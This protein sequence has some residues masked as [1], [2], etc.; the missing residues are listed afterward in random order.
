MSSSNTLTVENL[1]CIR[2]E[3]V[4]FE[5]LSFALSAGKALHV[6]GANGSGKTSL[7][8]LLCGINDADHGLIQWNGNSIQN[9][10]DY[11]KNSAYIGHKDGLKNELSAIENLRF[12]QQLEGSRDEQQLDD[13]LERMQILH[14]ADL[15]AYQLS[16]G[17][18]RRLAFARLLLKKF[19]LWI[20]D[21]PFTGID[22]DGRQLIEQVC[23]QHL[24][25]G[26]LITLTHHRGLE[27]SAFAKYVSKLDLVR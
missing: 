13:C 5:E 12:Y 25:S 16:F 7:L 4:L 22:S 17:Q 18:R 9:N 24:M 8:R 26:G 1:S 27:D 23:E 11:L 20:L 10:L 15:S 2:G 6:C 19:T 21:E 3:R 14:C